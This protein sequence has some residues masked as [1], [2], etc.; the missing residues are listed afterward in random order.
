MTS[1][2]E[3]SSEMPASL[4]VGE[5][6]ISG[7]AIQRVRR[8][9]AFTLLEIVVVIAV[10]AVL[11]G[12][13]VMSFTMFDDKAAFEKP[14]NELAAM[15]KQASRASVVL[16]RPVVIA[17]DKKGFGFADAGARG[18]ESRCE[19]PKSVK[20]SVQRWNAKNWTPAVDFIWT[21]YPSGI[22]DALRFKFQSDEGV[23]EM[24]FNPLTG[25]VT[26]EEKFVR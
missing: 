25:S 6:R 18:A 12:M 2:T 21:F 20:V 14:A 23:Q 16:G 17:F 11:A 8:N 9:A 3:A 15:V 26:S 4:E 10:I 13:A 19:L 24:A 22:S 1:R 5:S 7:G